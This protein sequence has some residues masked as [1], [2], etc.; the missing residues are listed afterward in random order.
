MENPY[1][2]ENIIIIVIN[3]IKYAVHNRIIQKMQ[4]IQNATNDCGNSTLEFQIDYATQDLIVLMIDIL[5]DFNNYSEKFYKL[6]ISDMS[7]LISIMKYFLINDTIIDNTIHKFIKYACGLQDIYE[8]SMC[9]ELEYIYDMMVK[10]RNKEGCFCFSLYTKKNHI[11]TILLNDSFSQRIKYK[12]IMNIL[13]FNDLNY[14]K[15]SMTIMRVNI[16]DKITCHVLSY[17]LVYGTANK[18]IIFDG[19]DLYMSI[20]LQDA[21]IS[22]Q[23][24]NNEG[25]YF[26]L[27][28]G[29]KKGISGPYYMDALSAKSKHYELTTH[30]S[31]QDSDIPT[32][33]CIIID[34]KEILFSCMTSLFIQFD[35]NEINS[36]FN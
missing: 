16:N 32:N 12:F 35:K 29:G 5:H 11:K 22:A 20:E 23:G 13:L 27:N 28:Y 3:G 9:S 15:F 21:Y 4:L 7:S 36:I 10:Y 30:S 18:Y 6:S 33:T 8:S 31:L 26:S 25:I 19:N 17:P 14:V 24:N 1:S 2:L 34:G